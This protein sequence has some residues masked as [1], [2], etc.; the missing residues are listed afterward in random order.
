MVLSLLLPCQGIWGSKAASWGW[1]PSLPPSLSR[2]AS[3]LPSHLRDRTHSLCLCYSRASACVG[4][5][6]TLKV[7][8][9]LWSPFIT[10]PPPPQSLLEGPGVLQLPEPSLGFFLS[11]TRVCVC[12]HRPQVL[13]PPPPVALPPTPTLPSWSPPPWPKPSDPV[14]KGCSGCRPPNSLRSAGRS[15]REVS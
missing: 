12:A 4:A 11:L 5:P 6:A 15:L 14:T 8:L 9:S 10:P 3:G 13:G 7:S 2:Q 1:P